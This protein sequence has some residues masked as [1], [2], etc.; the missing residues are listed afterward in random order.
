MS[1][2][3]TAKFLKQKGHD[4]TIFDDNIK[5]TADFVKNMEFDAIVKS[6]G[7]PFMKHNMHPIIHKA[8][9]CG[10]PVISNYDV[11]SVY[12][13]E[14]R[15]IVITGTNG[16]STTTALLHHIL[17]KAGVNVSM[18]GNIGIPYGDL[19][20]SDIY[21]FEMSSYELAVSRYMNFDVCCL[22]NIEPDHLE[23]HGSFENYIAAKHRGLDTAKTKII[24]CEDQYTFEKYKADAIIISYQDN[25]NADIYIKEHTLIDNNSVI[26]DLSAFSELRGTHN[27]QNVAFAYAVCKHLGIPPK[28]V[29]RY[30]AS[31][32]ALPHR[33][34]I[35]RKINDILFIN[36]SKATNPDSAAKA[37]DTYVGYKIFWLVGG[38]SKKT[39]IHKSIDKFLGSVYKIYLFGESMDE[40][41][42]AFKGMKDTVRCETLDRALQSAYADAFLESGPSVVLLSP[43]CA[44]FDQFE[45]YAK[46]GETFCELVK[47]LE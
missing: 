47:E 34:N 7:I 32:K 23:I 6:P 14:A 20:E 15:V 35:V 30:V 37:L 39:D 33:M 44:S 41:E 9:E 40:F 27:H 42:A 12:H 29:A 10:I 18:G 43:M 45:N 46:R 31:F 22:L 11:F 24:S 38:R 1:G 28:E 17:S 8:N 5:N 3:S 26:C 2:N 4:I 25:R 36:D 19:K 13:P 21:V 16:K